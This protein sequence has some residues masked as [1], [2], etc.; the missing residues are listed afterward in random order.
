MNYL[1]FTV[2]FI[3]SDNEYLDIQLSIINEKKERIKKLSL[4]LRDSQDL[5]KLLNIL[6]EYKIKTAI[7][8]NSKMK[9][10]LLKIS[11][12]LNTKEIFDSL[13]LK[14]IILDSIRYDY[15]EDFNISLGAKGYDLDKPREDLSNT[16]S[17]IYFCYQ[18]KEIF[19]KDVLNKDEFLK[20]K[21]KEL[22]IKNKKKF[23]IFI[24]FEFD[25]EN[26][27]KAELISIGSIV[28]K[29]LIT[30][31][32]EF[33]SLV[34]PV[35]KKSLSEECYE[36][37]HITQ[38]EL[39]N[40][41]N[42]NKVIS[43]FCDWIDK[44]NGQYVIYNWGNFDKVALSRILR[45]NGLIQIYNKYFRD[46]YDIQ[47]DV[48]KSITINDEIVSKCMGLEKMKEMYSLSGIVKHNAL[49]DS[50][51]LM[52]VVSSY[53]KGHFN[54]YVARKMYKEQIRK[55][56]LWNIEVPKKKV[57]ITYGIVCF[58]KSLNANIN[59]DSLKKEYS[60]IYFKLIKDIPMYL[61][62]VFENNNN[63]I[64]EVKVKVN[65]E[66]REIIKSFLKIDLEEMMQ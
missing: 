33:Y 61:L 7:T 63:N 23:Y 37:T 29:D 44:Y 16:L 21:N 64:Y 35:N 53:T 15:L 10:Q 2:S 30:T 22:N 34:K 52:K 62:L 54:I 50:E 39:D 4:H 25:I 17:E 51:D 58:I 6:K 45:Y 27:Q 42:I 13:V 41:D 55:T 3:Q 26:R 48:S 66:N 28:S 11:E 57:N 5:E 38:E 20:A 56:C 8:W 40:A 59:I 43:D 47:E 18:N 14:D 32:D 9:Q 24:D 19:N 12:D 46:M 49:S 65:L 31:T 1:F 60:K 36:I